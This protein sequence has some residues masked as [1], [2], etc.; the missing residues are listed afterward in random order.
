MATENTET[1]ERVYCV[2]RS[3]SLGVSLSIIPDSGSLLSSFRPSDP[4]L[5]PGEREPESRNRADRSRATDGF[6]WIPDS[7]L[8]GLPG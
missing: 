2:F 1:T 7:P 3:A 4:G 8:R 6:S 5:E